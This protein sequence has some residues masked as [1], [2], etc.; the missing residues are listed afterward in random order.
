MDI[1]QIKQSIKGVSIAVALLFGVSIT[2]N[3]GLPPSTPQGTYAPYKDPIGIITVCYGYVPRSNEKVQKEYTQK[4][5]DILLYKTIQEYSVVLKGLPAL[6]LSTTV[7]F[8]DFGYNAGISAANG[9]TVKKHLMK[10]DYEAASK[11]ILDWRFV[12]KSKLSKSDYSMGNWEYNKS[13]GKYFYDCSQYVNGKP[14][15]MCYG[16]YTRRLMESELLKGTMTDPTQ[17]E[18]FIK[19]YYYKDKK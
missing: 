3:E 8:L 19:Q 16:L 7:G 14:N 10:K 18:N 2:T 13:K 5:C 12:S 4:E 9:S 11:A 6:P 17:I 1:Q 15:K